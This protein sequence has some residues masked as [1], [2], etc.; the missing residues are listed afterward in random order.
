VPPRENAQSR[1]PTYPGDEVVAR[2]IG[3]VAHLAGIAPRAAAR[4]VAA[5]YGVPVNAAY[6][7][8]TVL[9]S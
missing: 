4:R 8:W 3:Q 7:L 5:K 2:E 9:K 1:R 6:R